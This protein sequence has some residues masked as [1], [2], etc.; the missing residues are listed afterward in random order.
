MTVNADQS[1]PAGETA[2]CA[3][4]FPDPYP[5]PLDQPGDCRHCDTSYQTARAGHDGPSVGEAADNERRWALEKE[6]E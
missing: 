3:H 2:A 4:S 1:G 5:A 6:G